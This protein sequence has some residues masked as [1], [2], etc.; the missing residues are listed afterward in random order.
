MGIGEARKHWSGH[1][2]GQLRELWARSGH[3]GACAELEDGQYLHAEAGRPGQEE[4]RPDQAPAFWRSRRPGRPAELFRTRVSA[5]DAAVKRDSWSAIRHGWATARVPPGFSESTDTWLGEQTSTGTAAE[6]P[7]TRSEQPCTSAWKVGLRSR[8]KVDQGHAAALA[9]SLRDLAQR[10]EQAPARRQ[11]RGCQLGRDA[12]PHH[13]ALQGRWPGPVQGPKETPESP[14]QNRV[15]LEALPE[16]THS[17][18][19]LAE[20]RAPGHGYDIECEPARGCRRQRRS[21]TRAATRRR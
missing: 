15:R 1:G 3:A 7:H 12:G 4:A 17:P 11:E 5:S 10:V 8:C 9:G 6:P 16:R 19:K 21:P 2:P 18:V 14:S 20:H 13:E